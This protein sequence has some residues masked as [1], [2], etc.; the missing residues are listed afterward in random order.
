MNDLSPKWK[1]QDFVTHALKGGG[2]VTLS[3]IGHL[4]DIIT[5]YAYHLG[6][7]GIF[8]KVN[9]QV[10]DAARVVGDGYFSY[11]FS[12]SYDFTAVAYPHGGS[13][14]SGIFKGYVSE[15]NGLMKI[16]GTVEYF[17]DD[18]YTDPADIRQGLLGTSDP[19]VK[20]QKFCGVS[21]KIS[22]SI[23]AR[24]PMRFR[25]QKFCGALRQLSLNICPA[26]LAWK[27][28]QKFCGSSPMVAARYT[29]S[30]ISGRQNC[31][32]RPSGIE[33]KA[34]INGIKMNKIW[35]YSKY[36]GFER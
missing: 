7:V 1:K 23:Y 27:R 31:M 30:P 17:F 15:K 29:P 6:E 9:G 11:E 25:F 5:H 33:M 18:D 14:V 12:R 4:Q 8:E 36:S 20:P 3:G 13:T 34:G 24:Y 22:G 19:R 10:I 21:Q 28:F 26:P 2:D 32:P 35:V 16:D